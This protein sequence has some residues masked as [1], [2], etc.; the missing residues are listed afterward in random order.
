[1]GFIHLHVHSEYSLSDGIVRIDEFARALADMNMPA[2]AITEQS[3]L[4]SAIKFY[5]AMQAGGIKPIIGCELNLIPPTQED[6]HSRIVL[7]CQNIIGYGNLSRLVTRSYIDGWHRGIPSITYEWLAELNEGLIALSCAEDGDAAQALLRKKKSEAEQKIT[8]WM[9]H[10]PDRFYL[11]LQRIGHDLQEVYIHRILEL[12]GRFNLPVVTSNNVRF[13]LPEDYEAHETRVCI[14]QGHIL[15]DTRRRQQYSAQQYLRSSEEMLELFDDIP[16]AIANTAHIAQ[17]CTIEF[18]LGEYFLPRFPVSDCSSQDEL[19]RKNAEAGFEQRLAQSKSDGINI[20]EEKYWKRLDAEI[21]IINSMGFAGYFLIVADFIH[22]A[23][24]NNIPV[25]PGRG[26]GAGSLVAYTLGITELDPV[27]FNLL[28]ER[29]LN[30]ERISPPDFDIDFCMDRRDEVIDYVANKY[31][32][33]RVSQIITFGTMAAKAVIRDVGRVLGFPYGFVDQ[34]A[35]LVPLDLNMTLARALAQEEQLSQRY[36]K[37]EEVKRLIDLA[38]KL[39]GIARNAGKHAGGLVIAPKA[40]T[41]YMPLYCEQGSD[42]TATQFDMGDVEAIGLVKFDFLGL[43]TLTIIDWAIKDTNRLRQKRKLEPVDIN[44]IPHNDKKVF[45]LIQKMQTTAIFQLESDGIRKLIKRLRP[46]SFDDL[47]ALVALFRPGPLQ[48]GMVDDFIDRKHGRAEVRYLHDSLEPILKSTYGVIL[49]QEQVMQIAQVL[50]GYT[51]GSADILRR[52]MGKKKPEEMA[53]QRE[54]FVQGAVERNINKGLATKIFDLME[55][56]A[57]YGFNKSHSAAYALIAYQTAWLKT[58]YSAA[59]MAAVLSADMENT[60]KVILLLEE[61]KRLEIDLL[62][63]T[64]NHSFYNFTTVN[65]STIRYGLGA[66]KGMGTIAADNI[67]EVREKNQQFSDLFDLCRRIDLRKVTKRSLEAMIKSGCLDELD[68]SRSILSANLDKAI[69]SAEQFLQNKKSGQVDLFGVGAQANDGADCFDAENYSAAYEHAPDWDENKRLTNEKEALGFYLNGHPIESY[70]DELARI[71]TVK[72]NQLSPGKIRVAGYIMEIRTKYNARGKSAEVRLDDRSAR[73]II[74]VYSEEY[75]TYR[76]LLLKDQL[77]IVSG[78]AAKDEYIAGGHS[79]KAKEIYTLDYFRERYGTLNLS[80][81]DKDVDA[82]RV[83][84]LQDIIAPFRKGN[85]HVLI[86]YNKDGTRGRINLGDD[87]K[88][89][90]NDELLQKLYTSFGMENVNVDY[91]FN[92]LP[93]Q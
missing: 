89:M 17:R 71:I 23:K 18:K 76:H 44:K 11:E 58:H 32:H 68:P 22:W 92:R 57:G 88:L 54:F 43:R 77:I 3:N 48:S 51:L 81:S 30:P 41:A 7:L 60:D 20:V 45:S 38:K 56:F 87:W 9:T 19:L 80:L 24:K 70:E 91:K 46:D 6:T 50:A 12:A 90:L 2:A 16:E 47:I 62:P 13:L 33:D 79:I 74:R 27:P 42:A 69:S 63:P 66:I 4:F 1:M 26:S 15:D 10:F 59:F 28:F 36:A 82:G 40:L 55:K 83:R 64:I 67:I 8:Y 5:R 72:L 29:F 61:L 49:Y 35:K 34:I 84:V 39:E 14:N 86:N 93:I 21:E 75:R 52:A 37:E 78:T 85:S 73:V 53:E 31:G 25:G 65:E